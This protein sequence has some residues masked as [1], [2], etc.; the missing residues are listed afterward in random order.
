MRSAH[1]S[2]QSQVSPAAPGRSLMVRPVQHRRGNQ[3]ES[4]RFGSY[5]VDSYQPFPF[6]TQWVSRIIST[7][8]QA[9][10]HRNIYDRCYIDS[11][12]LLQ[13]DTCLTFKLALNH[14]NSVLC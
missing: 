11:P 14:H 6:C 7:Q 9:M 5:A 12:E 2:D 8:S 4:P 1:S 13:F 3:G 10:Q